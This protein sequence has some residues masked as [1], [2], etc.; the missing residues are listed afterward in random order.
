MLWCLGSIENHEYYWVQHG[1]TWCNKQFHRI[2][3]AQLIIGYYRWPPII[4][5]KNVFFFFFFLGS[6]HPTTSWGFQSFQFRYRCPMMRWWP[7]SLASPPQWWT[8]CHWWPQPR[9]CDLVEDLGAEVDVRPDGF[10]PHFFQV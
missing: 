10:S 4:D 6:W 8:T 7:S 2:F 3:R 9:A 5:V 1:T